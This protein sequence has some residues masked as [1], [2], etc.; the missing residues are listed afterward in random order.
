MQN[1]FSASVSK[2]KGRE[3]YDECA[4]AAENFFVLDGL[5]KCMD[6]S[7]TEAE[8]I[9][10][11]RALYML[12]NHIKYTETAE[13]LWKKGKVIFNDAEFIRKIGLLRVPISLRRENCDSQ[14]SYVNQV[15]ETA[16][17]LRGTGFKIDEEWLGSLLLAGVPEKYAPMAMA[18]E[19]SGIT[20]TIHSKKKSKLVDMESDPGSAFN[21]FVGKFQSPSNANKKE[22][23]CCRCK[24]KGHYKIVRKELKNG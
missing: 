6:G 4:F 5:K 3:K 1:N 7:E 9:I 11:A 16:R 17:S 13:E 21:A 23:T 19:Y 8:K 22:V 20:I 2:L 12:Y 14:A 24:K 18:I 10:Q 15:V